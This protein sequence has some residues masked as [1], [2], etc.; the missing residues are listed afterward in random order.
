MGVTLSIV[1]FCR[2]EFLEKYQNGFYAFIDPIVV[3][4]DVQ[5]LLSLD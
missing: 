1:G 2:I 3:N 4:S 5:F